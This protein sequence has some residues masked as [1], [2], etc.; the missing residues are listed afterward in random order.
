MRY[1]AFEEVNTTVFSA[2]FVVRPFQSETY[3]RFVEFQAA[4][5]YS[6]RD[7]KAVVY[8][9]EEYIR[10]ASAFRDEIQ[11]TEVDK[12]IFS[13]IK[14]VE[15]KA[16]PLRF[17]E[18]L[19][20]TYPNAFVYLISSPL[21]GTWVGA[22]PEILLTNSEG[23]GNTVALAGT[24]RTSDNTPWGKKEEQEQQ[25]VTSYIGEKLT[26]LGLAEVQQS[27]C[28]ES[29]AGPVK[30]LKT[31]FRFQLP[32]DRVVEVANTLHPTPAVCGIP[33]KSSR[34]LIRNYETH[35]RDLYTGFLGVIGEQTHL[36]VNLRCAELREDHTLLF[37]GG[38][39]TADSDVESEWEETEN[40]SRTL[41]DVL[42]RIS[43]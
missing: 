3:Y 9:K 19:V 22:S 32:F 1:G 26:S 17:Y 33:L 12:G 15:V 8:L 25:Y 40:K 11:K 10:R 31:D 24:K 43:L 14:R 23:N 30:H 36:Y 4:S 41:L 18:A 34:E 27:S 16:D 5:A 35:A 13:R 42:E 37:L 20:K 29:M 38:G 39:F 21:F 2:G 7:S 6:F 28:Y